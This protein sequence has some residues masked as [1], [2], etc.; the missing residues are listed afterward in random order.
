MLGAGEEIIK[1]IR[2]CVSVSRDPQSAGKF[3]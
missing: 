1:K 3:D 2:E